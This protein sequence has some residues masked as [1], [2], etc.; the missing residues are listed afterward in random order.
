M[1][2][3]PR[4]PAALAA[5]AALLLSGCGGTGAFP[6]P[7]AKNVEYAQRNGQVTTL[8]ALKL[9]RKLYIG[10]CSGC[11]S[12]KK[13]AFLSPQDWPEMVGR[14]AD[15]AHLTADQQRAVTQ[16]IVSASAAV[17]DTATSAGRATGAA[18]PEAGPAGP[19]AGPGKAST[20]QP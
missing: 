8:E 11:H 3:L 17:R 19:E 6:A 15:N 5:A 20:N 16:Y 12:L 13:P 2:N 4:L 18:G 9:G 7:T 10:R 1:T 14:M